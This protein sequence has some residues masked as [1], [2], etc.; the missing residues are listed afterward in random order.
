[1]VSITKPSRDVI[2][3]VLTDC[4]RFLKGSDLAE[5]DETTDVI[6]GF[7]LDSMDGI[8]LACDLSTRLRVEIPLKD[9]PLIEDDAKTGR[10]RSRKFGEIVNYLVELAG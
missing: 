5:F 4:L 8:E 9:N 3:E 10:K 6:V 2:R 7:G 1:M